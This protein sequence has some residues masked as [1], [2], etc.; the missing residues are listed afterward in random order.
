MP[1]TAY[2]HMI[3]YIKLPKAVV[4]TFSRHDET[5]TNCATRLAIT[6]RLSTPRYKTTYF[7]L[8]CLVKRCIDSWN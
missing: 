8:K 7:G 3:T 5:N 2:L 6:G 1:Q 4:N